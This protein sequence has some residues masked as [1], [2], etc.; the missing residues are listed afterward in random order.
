LKIEQQPLDTCEVQ[1]KIELE[2]AQ[3]DEAKRKA[4]RKLA[5]R[6]SIPGFR[7]GK[8]PYE[9]V[10][11]HLGEDNVLEAAVEDLSQTL[12][13]Q[14][15][16]ELDLDAV[17]PGQ[18]T[19][20]Q[21]DPPVFTYTVPLRPEVELGN[22]RDVRLGYVEA[23][24]TEE[25]LNESLEH[26]REYEAVLE[27]V[28]RP[29]ELGD[30]ITVDV[31]GKVMMESAAPREESASAPAPD[32]ESET[33]PQPTE[34]F[35]MDDKDVEVLLDP[36]LNWPA[37]GFADKVAGMKIDEERR[38]ELTFPDDYPNESLRGKGAHFEVICKGMKS[39]SLPEWDDELAKSLG[40]YESLA[41][42]RAKVR[43]AL[44]AQAKRRADEEYAKSAVDIVVAGA[45]VKYPKYLLE[46]EIE[47]MKEDLDRRLRERNLT[48]ED[49]KKI[50]GV[51]D[52][53]LREDLEPSARERLRRSLTIS[54]V[55]EAE[56]L[57]VGDD[58]VEG[59]IDLMSALFGKDSDRYRKMMQTANAR[60]SVR[61]DLLSEQAVK[62]VVAIAKGENPPLPA[63]TEIIAEAQPVDE[64]APAAEL[65]SAPAPAPESAAEQKAE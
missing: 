30:V 25:A 51:T 34:E 50:S 43:E 58:E 2:P 20:A 37:P 59:R 62:R 54:K 14:A 8:A 12:Y 57:T 7:K 31:V 55:I 1:L 22:Y 46:S 48:L 15:L 13:K 35:L 40:N 42:L 49:Y 41:D 6:Y 29:A 17:G 45:T 10:I 18:M 47:D 44:V 5:Q 24:V 36:K 56:R 52:E 26:M 11:R 3:I 64:A 53:K 4:A 16:D 27:P 19:D 33:Q 60:R 28:D 63:T 32:S 38:V 21:L 9:I 65:D 61:F 39:R 23:D